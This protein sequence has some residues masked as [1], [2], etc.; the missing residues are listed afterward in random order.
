MDKLPAVLVV[1]HIFFVRLISSLCIY[2]QY[3]CWSSAA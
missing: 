1:N 3:D 2:A